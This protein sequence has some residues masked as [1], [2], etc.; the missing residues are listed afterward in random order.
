M[1]HIWAADTLRGTLLVKTHAEML[2]H[3]L[4]VAVLY[5]NCVRRL[6]N[7]RTVTARLVE[8]LPP[9]SRWL[10]CTAASATVSRLAGYW[11]VLAKMPS[12]A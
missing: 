3:L 10:L 1:S 2:H 4:L 9:D 5:L 12:L 7:Q 6:V 8:P 11:S